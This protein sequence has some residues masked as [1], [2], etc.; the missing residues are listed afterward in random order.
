MKTNKNSY[1]LRSKVVTTNSKITAPEQTNLDSFV[2]IKENVDYKDLKRQNIE[3]FDDLGDFEDDQIL[4]NRKKIRLNDYELQTVT[5]TVGSEQSQTK[6]VVDQ[7]LKKMANKKGAFSE[8]LESN[9]SQKKSLNFKDNESLNNS[10]FPSQVMNFQ[11]PTKYYDSN[12]DS[13]LD[14]QGSK[15]FENDQKYNTIMLPIKKNLNVNVS[16]TTV[17]LIQK[18]RQEK[19]LNLGNENKAPTSF[20]TV[21]PKARIDLNQIK[22]KR[23]SPDQ[24]YSNSN[25]KFAE[26]KNRVSLSK[27]TEEIIKN[28]KSK[29]KSSLKNQN[30]IEQIKNSSKTD[31]AENTVTRNKVQKEKNEEQAINKILSEPSMKDKYSEVTKPGKEI[32]LPADFSRLFNIFKQI[33]QILVLYQQ[34]SNPTFWVNIQTQLVKLL[35]IRVSIQDFQRIQNV[36]PDSYKIELVTNE[37]SRNLE[38]YITFPEND[39]KTKNTFSEAYLNQR[40]GQFRG[41]LLNIV[42]EHHNGWIKENKFKAH[43]YELHRTWHVGFDLHSINNEH[44]PQKDLPARRSEVK[45]TVKEFLEKKENCLNE[46]IKK[47]MQAAEKNFPNFIPYKQTGPIQEGSQTQKE[48][49]I[50][51]IKQKE[52]ALA[53]KINEDK[54]AIESGANF[55]NH[56][57]E[58][59]LIAQNLKMHYASR[60]VSNMFI[61]KVIDYVYRSAFNSMMEKTRIQNMQIHMCKILPDWLTIVENPDGTILRMNKSYE[62]AK[63][64]EKLN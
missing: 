61:V 14:R 30:L 37:K 6:D 64:T 12:P 8:I 2:D 46:D 27:K 50:E 5:S 62:F 42:S 19:S 40:K 43:N 20:A 3:A 15:N 36:F 34:K 21:N 17:Q 44:I 29:A 13:V 26:P 49:I 53:E 39:Y 51:V 18:V 56:K 52:K 57:K 38:F 1:R 55:Q 48:R 10:M 16:S 54:K 28:I 11:N 41:N 22:A 23:A 4:H 45:L 33:D 9:S 31:I 58:L 24:K 59:K 60:Q 47:T 7:N 35:Q 63:V 32:Q 25:Q